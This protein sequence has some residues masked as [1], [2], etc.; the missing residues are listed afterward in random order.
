MIHGYL[1]V[2]QLLASIVVAFPD[3]FQAVACRRH[4]GVVEVASF[5]VLLLHGLE[6]HLDPLVPYQVDHPTWVLHAPVPYLPGHREEDRHLL[7][8]P[9]RKAVAALP[10]LD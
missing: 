5:L 4:Q 3:P 10:L 1:A 9:S 2:T 6:Q 7:V 8:S